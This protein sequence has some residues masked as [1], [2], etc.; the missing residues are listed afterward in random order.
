M[1]T[2]ICQPQNLKNQFL[3]IS[4]MARTCQP[5]KLS[6]TVRNQTFKMPVK[7]LGSVELRNSLK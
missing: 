4:K 5:D 7:R 2:K 6:Q 3:K 1:E